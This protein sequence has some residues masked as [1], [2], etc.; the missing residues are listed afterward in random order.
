MIMTNFVSLGCHNVLTVTSSCLSNQTMFLF[1]GTTVTCYDVLCEFETRRAQFHL[2]GI[3]DFL[4]LNILAIFFPLTLLLTICMSMLTLLAR[5]RF[6]GI[7]P[8]ARLLLDRR[9]TCTL[10]PQYMLAFCHSPAFGFTLAALW[11]C[12]RL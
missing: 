2:A 9:F 5:M 6:Y 11:V 3:D 1:F 10:L 8:H 12:R 7:L 4:L